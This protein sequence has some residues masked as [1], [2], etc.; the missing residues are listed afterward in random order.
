[1]Q[2][3]RSLEVSKPRD[4]A[5]LRNQRGDLQGLCHA[6]RQ[7]AGAAAGQSVPAM[8]QRLAQ[9]CNA[10]HMVR[11]LRL[12][13]VP[14]RVRTREKVRT[15]PK[16]APL[17]SATGVPPT[18]AANAVETCYRQRT[19]TR[20]ARA[21]LSRHARA[22]VDKP[23]RAK[24][25]TAPESVPT[26]LA[27]SVPQTR[28]ANAA[29]TCQRRPT[30]TLGVTTAPSRRARAGVDL[31]A[32]ERECIV[33]EC[34]PI[35]L[36]T[37]V[38]QTRAANAAEAWQGRPTQTLGATTA[39]SRHARGGVGERAPAGMSTAPDVGPPGCA[40]SA[41]ASQVRLPAKSATSRAE[42]RHKS[43]RPD[44]SYAQVAQGLVRTKELKLKSEVSRQVRKKLPA[45]GAEPARTWLR[46]CEHAARPKRAARTSLAWSKR[47]YRSR[48]VGAAERKRPWQTCD[49]I[50]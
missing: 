25:S 44:Q 31:P 15:T 36:A 34:A 38:P 9:I 30:Q 48:R 50:I 29:E 22:G 14:G 47:H 28:A 16:I 43:D 19:Q 46:P 49:V 11:Q 7:A 42:L 21:A 33:P 24:E 6:E 39:P 32:R 4:R 3:V 13:A 40:V 23:V 2:A 12:P 17:G 35:G 27:T 41:R 26:G 37:S 1:M 20:G 10:R 5:R 18:S 45:T 8:R